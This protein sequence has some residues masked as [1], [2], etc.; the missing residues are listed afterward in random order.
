[1][2][3]NLTEVGVLGRPERRKT[4]AGGSILILYPQIFGWLLTLSTLRSFEEEP[5]G[6]DEG[7]DYTNFAAAIHAFDA[8]GM[9]HKKEGVMC[10]KCLEFECECGEELQFIDPSG[11][12]RH[13]P[14]NRR[15]SY[16]DDSCITMVREWVAR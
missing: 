1:M 13:R 10:E 4:L 6:W 8:F 16:T 7:W 12:V 3:S 15:R 14:S 9:E 11:W 2:K 5:S